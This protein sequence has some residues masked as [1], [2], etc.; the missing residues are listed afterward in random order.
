MH[1]VK[2]LRKDLDN[3]KKK[4]KDRNINFDTSNFNKLDE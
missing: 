4:I 1:N 2:D 3:F